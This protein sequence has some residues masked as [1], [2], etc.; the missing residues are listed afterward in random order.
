M[1]SPRIYKTRTTFRWKV[2]GWVEANPK[3]GQDRKW[4]NKFYTSKPTAEELQK[5]FKKHHIT[6]LSVTYEQIST[7]PWSRL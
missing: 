4:W 7:I 5:H 6:V 1:S 3:N 2:S